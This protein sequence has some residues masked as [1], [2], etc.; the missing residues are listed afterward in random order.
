MTLYPERGG[1]AVMARFAFNELLSRRRVG[2][3]ARLPDPDRDQ[4]AVDRPLPERVLV[5]FGDQ[6]PTSPSRCS[7]V[8]VARYNYL[9]RRRAGA[10]RSRW[11]SS[12]W[13]WS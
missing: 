10:A 6:G 2:D 8:L 11:R 7:L 9:G 13:R 12:T 5:G 1:S 4:H 3:P